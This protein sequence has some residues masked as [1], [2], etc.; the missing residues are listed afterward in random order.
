MWIKAEWY[1]WKTFDKIK[2]DSYDSCV[3][4][5]II[6]V[7]AVRTAVAWVE[8]TGNKDTRATN[9]TSRIHN[10]NTAVVYYTAVEVYHMYDVL[11]LL[12]YKVSH[13]III[14]PCNV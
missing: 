1:L 12:L 2:I 14:K 4:A 13:H 8:G 10:N 3:V 9:F 6:E 11:L 5:G 7:Q